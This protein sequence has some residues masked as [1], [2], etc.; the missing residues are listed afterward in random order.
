MNIAF[1]NQLSN[2]KK[3]TSIDAEFRDV[4]KSLENLKSELLKH[5]TELDKVIIHT[6][7]LKS[8]FQTL[9]NQ[10][11]DSERQLKSK[12]DTLEQHINTKYPF[13]HTSNIKIDAIERHL[14][15]QL[16]LLQQRVEDLE[17]K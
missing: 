4:E 16:A 5:D 15:N 10:T 12:L 17:K 6:S 2:F 7:K 8:E 14:Q 3:A 9:E 11:R 13:P 1:G